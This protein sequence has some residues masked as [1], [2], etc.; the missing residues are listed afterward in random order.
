MTDRTTQSDFRRKPRSDKDPSVG[1]PS[2]TAAVIQPVAST[3][4]STRYVGLDVHKQFLVTFQARSEEKTG[5]PV[6]D[7]RRGLRRH[8]KRPAGLL[9]ERP[10]CGVI[11]PRR[12][13]SPRH[14]SW[15]LDHSRSN[16]ATEVLS[17]VLSLRPDLPNELRSI[18]IAGVGE[19]DVY[20]IVAARCTDR[21]CVELC[22]RTAG[23]LLT[24]GRVGLA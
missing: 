18:R 21:S 23:Q 7:E 4:P 2:P 3:D 9:R 12:H 1:E 8:H 19:P 10:I 6:A 20:C 11:A 15:H 14:S 13:V 5:H 17:G 22:R 24:A 16:A